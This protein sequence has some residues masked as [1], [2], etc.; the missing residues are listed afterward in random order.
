MGMGLRRIP[1]A[2]YDALYPLSWPPLY[3]Q[4]VR[5]GPTGRA[6][7]LG[8]F[9]EPYDSTIEERAGWAAQGYLLCAFPPRDARGRRDPVQECEDRREV[10]RVP[11]GPAAPGRACW[12]DGDVARTVGDTGTTPGIHRD[13]P[14]HHIEK[15]RDRAIVP[16]Y[17]VF[18]SPAVLG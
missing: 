9:A 6:G 18:K 4:V 5:R 16:V 10:L 2:V 3:R 13:F 12:A 7:T 8:R 15:T 14:P 11:S 1:P 17:R